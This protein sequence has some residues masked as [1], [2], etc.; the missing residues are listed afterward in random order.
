MIVL[1]TCSRWQNPAESLV[2]NRKPKAPLTTQNFRIKFQNFKNFPQNLTASSITITMSL[3]P[4]LQHG[5]SSS[6]AVRATPGT[7]YTE[8]ELPPGVES[9]QGESRGRTGLR[10]PLSTPEALF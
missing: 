8:L 6:L 9:E 10:I 1:E 2:V 7:Q 3:S 5:R 4:T